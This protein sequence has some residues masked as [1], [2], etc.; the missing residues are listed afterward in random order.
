MR[1]AS[2][3]TTKMLLF[4]MSLFIGLQQLSMA[5][6]YDDDGDSIEDVESEVV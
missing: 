5:E 4:L 2:M 6:I 3:N 1:E